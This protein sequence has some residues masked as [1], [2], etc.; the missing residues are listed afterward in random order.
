MKSMT[1]ELRV[2]V[3]GHELE[4]LAGL[5]AE[6]LVQRLRN[7]ADYGTVRGANN[8]KLGGWNIWLDGEEGEITS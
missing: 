4:T 2:S 3:E 7:G 6:Q 1:L 8:E 5:M